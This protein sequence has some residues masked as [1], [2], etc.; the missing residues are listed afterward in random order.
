MSGAVREYD[1]LV[2]GGGSS[3]IASARRARE[4]NVS[5]ALIE[6][7]RLGG[8]CVCIYYFISF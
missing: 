6:E 4:F 5:A 8:T 1:Y 2:I 7:G 3:G